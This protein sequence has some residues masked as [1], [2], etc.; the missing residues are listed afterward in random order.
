MTSDSIVKN[1]GDEEVE[2]IVAEIE[3]EKEAEAEK[4][5]KP[6]ASSANQ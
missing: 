2:A 5:K 6:S 1:L 3:K 4:K